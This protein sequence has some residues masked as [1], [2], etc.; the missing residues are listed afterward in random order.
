M[1]RTVLIIPII[2]FTTLITGSLFAQSVDRF[3]RDIRIAE[4]IIEQLFEADRSSE[5]F[6]R[7]HIRDVT[8]QY[9]TGYGIHFRIAANLTPAIVRV[10]LENQTEIHIDAD[11]DADELREMGRDYVEQRLMEYL[12]S[13][14][15]LFKN[16]PDD[17]VIRLTVG[18]YNSSGSLFIL[19]PGT[20]ESRRTVANITAWAM[21]SDIQAYDGNS[22][23]E[24]EFETRVEVVDL[25][26]LETER[27]QTVF[28]SILQTSLMEVSDTIRVRRTPV[29][30]YL[31]GL[32]LSYTVNASFRSGRFFNFG[33][34]DIQIKELKIESD[35][36]SIDFSNMLDDINFDELD[37]IA[38]RIDSV[39]ATE[40]PRLNPDS[41]RSSLRELRRTVEQQR[42]T[43]SEETVRTLV[44]QFQ[45]ILKQTVQDYGPTLRSLDGDEMLMITVN[46]SG[47]HSALPARTEL[48]IR[49]SGILDGSEPVIEEIMRR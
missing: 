31:P 38:E 8:G 16:L 24:Q 43:L 22:I 20:S 4:G 17:E 45:N 42:N 32:G 40:P 39:F 47:R 27:D 19:R 7:R 44:D 1:K 46:W 26:N 37:S 49:K 5:Y 10:V 25:A 23:S 13:Y 6:G 18:P 35:S 3:D 34:L 28:A 11:P 36:L 30:E 33:D 2:L 41:M 9:I 14:A 48:R 21:V 12:K 15:P 29:V